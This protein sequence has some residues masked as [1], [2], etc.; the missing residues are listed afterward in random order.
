MT[1]AGAGGDTYQPSPTDFDVIAIATEWKYKDRRK[2]KPTH[3]LEQKGS[4]YEVSTESPHCVTSKIEPAGGPRPLG[5]YAMRRRHCSIP[6]AAHFRRQKALIQLRLLSAYVDTVQRTKLRLSA[7][8]AMRRFN[9]LRPYFLLHCIHILRHCGA[10]VTKFT[11]LA[12]DPVGHST[13]CIKYPIASQEIGNVGIRALR[14]LA[15][16]EL[17]AINNRR[18]P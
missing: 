10:L 16:R 7:N 2:E 1:S 5:T 6:N 15:Q 3:R 11:T 18:T 4:R 17:E 13:S 12:R 8:D 14:T 9:A